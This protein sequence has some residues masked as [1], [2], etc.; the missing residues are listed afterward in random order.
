MS[1]IKRIATEA[2]KRLQQR[3]LVPMEVGPEVADC[4]NRAPE[5]PKYSGPSELKDSG[6]RQQFSSGAVRDAQARKGRFDLM[7]NWALYA[8]S[9]I[10]EAGALKY[11][12]RNWEKGM[13]ISRYIE[14]AQ[15]HLAKY[16]MGFRDEPHLWQ[17]LWNVANA[18][19]TQILVYI[20]VYPTEYYD[21]PNHVDNL[22]PPILSEFEAQ[23]VDEL[24]KGAPKKEVSDAGSCVR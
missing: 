1:A 21:L 2:K 12:D 16:V 4:M 5:H 9:W 15:R 17:A 22:G 14:S 3:G 13:P 7:S 11:A 6:T 18:I 23:R 24:M 10:M 19:H 20:G 8:Y